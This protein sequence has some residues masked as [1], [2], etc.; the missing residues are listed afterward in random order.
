[1]REAQRHAFV[2]SRHHALTKIGL[3]LEML[4][5]YQAARG[6]G[7]GEIYLPMTR[8]DIADYIG[9][10]PE[11]VSRSFRVRSVQG[12][13]AFRNRHHVKIVNR[14]RFN[15]IASESENLGLQRH[16]TASD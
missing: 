9:I 10:S 1:L 13:I 5:N 15:D 6:E 2:L 11:A 8:S 16:Q 14:A 7:A 3:F 4:E 12:V